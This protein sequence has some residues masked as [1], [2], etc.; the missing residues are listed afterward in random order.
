VRRWTGIATFGISLLLAACRVATSSIAP[1]VQATALSASTS[2][3]ATP[4]AQSG[5][6]TARCSAAQLSVGL[7]D[8]PFSEP[9]GQHSVALIITNTSPSGC[10]LAGYPQVAFL[11][12]ARRAIPFQYQTSGDQVVTSAPPA[13]VDLAA[14]ALAWVTINKYRCDTT[15]L[16]QASDL[17]ITLPG[18]GSSFE[19][20][21]T[22]PDYC[23]PGDPGSIV[24][25]SPVEPTFAAT[26]ASG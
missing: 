23:G 7:K 2:P 13:H 15:D 4:S 20:A 14:H 3:S 24:H 21:V 22:G 19:V 8:G 16:M 6:L 12:S 11:D 26:I 18:Q 9:T 25:V 5:I 1:T 10:Y 17:R